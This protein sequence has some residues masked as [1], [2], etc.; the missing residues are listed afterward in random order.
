MIDLK[1]VESSTSSS[2][3]PGNSISG[4][5]QSHSCSRNPVLRRASKLG[6]FVLVQISIFTFCCRHHACFSVSG[7]AT[8]ALTLTSTQTGR[9]TTTHAI[10]TAASA[11]LHD[12]SAADAE[13]VGLNASQQQQQQKQQQHLQDLMKVHEQD[14]AKLQQAEKEKLELQEKLQRQIEANRQMQL[15]QQQQQPQRPATAAASDPKKDKA[16]LQRRVQ[17]AST[18][19]VLDATEVERHFAPHE[20][21]GLA[22]RNCGNVNEA[23]LW[24]NKS[25]WERW[26]GN[27][28]N[29]PADFKFYQ[30][31][32]PCCA[33]GNPHNWIGVP[34]NKTTP[35][36]HV[37]VT[38]DGHQVGPFQMKE[39]LKVLHRTKHHPTTND[40]NNNTNTTTTTNT[41][42]AALT[43]WIQGDSTMSQLWVATFCAIVRLGATIDRCYMN[44]GHIFHP[45]CTMLPKNNPSNDLSTNTTDNVDHQRAFFTLPSSLFDKDDN[46]NSTDRTTRAELRFFTDVCFCQ[47]SAVPTP[48]CQAHDQR[49]LNLVQRL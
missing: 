12:A 14:L 30:S 35:L 40:T 42:S 3:S 5:S 19:K 41:N 25:G 18:W 20:R 46:D 33:S 29:V 32:G 16:F 38:K 6:L 10:G 39:L 31:N 17:D 4:Q 1:M 47:S 26:M 8:S 43:I 49:F 11:R 37:E 48:P 22:T 21:Q 24:K 2:S 7:G 13:A 27:K 34:L 36:T 44:G 9:I 45:L 23:S 15:Q 28:W